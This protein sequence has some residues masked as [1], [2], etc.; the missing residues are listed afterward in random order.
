MRKTIFIFLISSFLFAS[1][2]FEGEVEHIYKVP[3][4]VYIKYKKGEINLSTLKKYSQPISF[5]EFE[6][7][8]QNSYVV[9]KVVYKYV[10]A[11]KQ[12][13]RVQIKQIGQ[14]Q[15]AAKSNKKN[16]LIANLQKQP[17]EI[18]IK[19]TLANFNKLPIND[20]QA[21]ANI[22]LYK[23]KQNP[24]LDYVSIKQDLQTNGLTKEFLENLL[25]SLKEIKD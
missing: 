20:K 25:N 10:K 14:S 2:K 6:T 7:E 18:I 9:K 21:I 1:V 5:E 16:E 11:H 17:L 19:Y 23:V 22:I 13:K 12:V 8:I 15:T 24:Q 4:N 3:I